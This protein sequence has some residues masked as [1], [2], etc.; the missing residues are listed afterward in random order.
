M[1][2]SAQRLENGG[3]EGAR[4]MCEHD[5]CELRR[6]CSG[7]VDPYRRHPHRGGRRGAR[8]RRELNATLLG[9][10]YLMETDFYSS[11]IER[12]GIR[13]VKPDPRQTIELQDMIYDELTRGVVSETS[14]K[15]FMERSRPTAGPAAGQS[16]VFAARNLDFYF[17]AT[18]PAPWPLVDSAVA[19]M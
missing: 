6:R 4:H 11:S 5:A 19:C 17:D 12:A 7:R 1:A 3:A 18:E 14:R 13:V 16:W 8:T 15:R 2:P 9:T 10:K